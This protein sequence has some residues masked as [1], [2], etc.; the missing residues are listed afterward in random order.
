MDLR[1]RQEAGRL[2][3]TF[4]RLRPCSGLTVKKHLGLG[5]ISNRHMLLWLVSRSSGNLNLFPGY[6]HFSDNPFSTKPLAR[7][8]LR[9]IEIR[10]CP[11]R[12]Q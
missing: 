10:C 4:P 9:V 11:L 6:R 1:H 3:S 2:I 8:T 7:R 5:H 12:R